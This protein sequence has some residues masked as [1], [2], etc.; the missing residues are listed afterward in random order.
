MIRL[1]NIKKIWVCLFVCFGLISVYAETSKEDL[2]TSDGKEAEQFIQDLGDKGIKTLTGS[3]LSAQE[4]QRRF[5]S[6][7][8]VAFDYERIGKF[9]LGRFRRDVKPDEMKKYLGLFK[10]MVVRVYAARFGEYDEEKFEVT[11]NRIIDNKVDT[12]VVSSRIIRRN[13]SKVSIEWHIYKSKNK[14]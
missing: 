10:G 8:V 3:G 7:F 6:L 5:E 2:G 12:V 13:D 4:R 14:W 1:I 9:V 11:G